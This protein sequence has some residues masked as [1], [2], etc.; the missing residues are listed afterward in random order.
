M[1]RRLVSLAAQLLYRTRMQMRKK[2]SSDLGETCINLHFI[3]FESCVM[4][5]GKNP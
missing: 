4:N 1:F 5:S 2:S 3:A